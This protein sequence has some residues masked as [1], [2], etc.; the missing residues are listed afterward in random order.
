MPRHSY[1]LAEDLADASRLVARVAAGQSLAALRAAA[2]LRPAVLEL[3][4]G[5]LRDYGVGDA[6][7]AGLVHRMP[8][9][10]QVRALLVTALRALRAGRPQH[11]VV[12]QAVDAVARLRIA[13][14][15]GLVNAVLRGYLRD[16]AALESR[17]AATDEGRYRHPQWWIDRVRTQYPDAWERLLAAGNTHPPMTLRVNVR[18][19]RVEEYLARLAAEG[20]EA[21]RVG[22]HAVRLATPRPVEAVPGFDAGLVSVQ[23]AGAQLAAPLL[24]LAPG[25]RVLDACAAP[26]GKAAHLA[27]LAPVELTALDVDEARLQR[28]HAALERLGLAARVLAGDALAPEAWWDGRPFQRILL[29]APCTASG[30]VRRYPDVKWL[31]RAADVD[32]FATQQTRLLAALWRL[33]GAGGKLL[34]ATCSVFDTENGA[35]VNEFLARHADAT[36]LAAPA[37][38]GAQLLPDADHDGF[39]YALLQKTS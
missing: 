13:S 6:L 21:R 18:R 10:P 7:V 38:D 35:V 2:P 16:R 27:E 37:L 17:A 8:S 32:R 36:R 34:Y 5:T 19:A 26:G 4:Y 31:R 23:D 29:D 15:K 28:L 20:I 11:A 39:Y 12:S 33:L 9:D 14:A 22:P 3:V 25:Q 30:V 1:S 24:D